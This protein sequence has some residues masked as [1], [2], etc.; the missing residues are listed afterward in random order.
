MV[1]GP[2]TSAT[3]PPLI[4]DLRAFNIA[5]SVFNEQAAGR[6]AGEDTKHLLFDATGDALAGAMDRCWTAGDPSTY[7][8]ASLAIHLRDSSSPPHRTFGLLMAEVTS[9]AHYVENTRGAQR[10]YSHLLRY[11]LYIRDGMLNVRKHEAKIGIS[12]GE[13]DSTLRAE[14]GQ[15]VA[16]DAELRDLIGLLRRHGI[17]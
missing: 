15:P 1:L 10:A 8:I 13:D 4:E 3:L 14:D 17:S 12:S 16:N 11:H 5:H 6:E 7:D 9:W 2:E